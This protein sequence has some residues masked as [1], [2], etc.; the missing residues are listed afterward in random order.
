MIVVTL[1]HEPWRVVCTASPVTKEDV[2][3]LYGKEEQVR[4]KPRPPNLLQFEGADCADY[5]Q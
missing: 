3:H 5:H 2:I 4:S 1:I